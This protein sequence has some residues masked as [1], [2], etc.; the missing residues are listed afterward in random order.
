MLSGLVYGLNFPV[1]RSSVTS[2]KLTTF[3][4]ASMVIFLVYS[5]QISGIFLFLLSLF[6][7]VF[8]SVPQA[9]RLGK[10][11]FQC[12]EVVLVATGGNNPPVHKSPLRR[13][14]PW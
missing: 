13:S 14:F 11:Q 9:L 3:L 4:F 8:D 1:L 6:L 10:A 5:S 12:Q 7:L 2:R